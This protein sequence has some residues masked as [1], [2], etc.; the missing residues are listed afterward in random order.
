MDGG[1][2]IRSGKVLGRINKK[3]KDYMTFCIE[4]HILQI[5]IVS[6]I[7]I[8]DSIYNIPHVRDDTYLGGGGA[9]PTPRSLSAL[10]Y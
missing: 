2:Q 8:S 9:N 4:E 10:Y 6:T 3:I 1:A 5:V 7:I